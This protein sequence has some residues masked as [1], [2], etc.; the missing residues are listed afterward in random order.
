MGLYCY[1]KITSRW[2]REEINLGIVIEL[3]IIESDFV[4]W[5]LPGSCL[6]A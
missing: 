4:I 5:P 2:N 3:C 1:W 6:R